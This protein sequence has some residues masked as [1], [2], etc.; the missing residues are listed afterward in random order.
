MRTWRKSAADNST[1]AAGVIVRAWAAQNDADSSSADDQ[2]RETNSR[3]L[4][5]STAGS[6]DGAAEAQP[7]PDTGGGSAAY[8][9]RSGFIV[10]CDPQA[11][12]QSM[13]SLTRSNL[14]W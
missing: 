11:S 2:S 8:Q 5:G 7:A 12:N 1:R 9:T 3:M 14:S 6:Y 4:S 13:P 10:V